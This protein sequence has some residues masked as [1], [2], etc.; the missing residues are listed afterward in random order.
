MSWGAVGNRRHAS[1]ERTML[2]EPREV[3]HQ[4]LHVE[5]A[6][7]AGFELVTRVTDTGPGVWEWHNGLGPRPQFVSE[8]L[9]RYWMYERLRRR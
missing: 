9:A 2:Q 8:R 4:D 6:A 5:R 7:S 3:T 1:K